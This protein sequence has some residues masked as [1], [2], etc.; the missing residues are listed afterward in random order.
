MLPLCDIIILDQILSHQTPTTSENCG[1][2]RDVKNGKGIS[3]EFGREVIDR[4][5]V[6]GM[7]WERKRL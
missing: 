3:E 6:R 4:K 5:K 7:S 2:L 1:I